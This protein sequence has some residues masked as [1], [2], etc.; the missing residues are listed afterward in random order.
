MSLLL[1][2]IKGRKNKNNQR[3]YQKKQIR[4]NEEIKKEKIR[5]KKEERRKKKEERRKKKEER[6]KK[7][8]ERKKEEREEGRKKKKERKKGVRKN[9][10]EDIQSISKSI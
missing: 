6:R 9:D 7:K 3:S 2:Y 10:W 8:E 1:K 4:N 5:K